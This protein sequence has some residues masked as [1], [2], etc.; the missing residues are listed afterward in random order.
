LAR[1]P[2]PPEDFS[3]K[4]LNI[5]R[6][7]SLFSNPALQRRL[8]VSN[9]HDGPVELTPRIAATVDSIF[10]PV[11][12]SY[13][14]VEGKLEG[15]ITHGTRRFYVYESLTG[16]QVRCLFADSIPLH[17]VLEAFEHRVSVSGVIR[18]KAKTGERLSIV[19]TE[20]RVF[21]DDKD[22]LSHQE[23]LQLWRAH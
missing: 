6:K 9:G 11:T 20:F 3:D 19:P 17:Q 12:E 14:S 1:F 21:R 4:S 7:L 15:I 13:G 16:R 10:G 2:D 8:I 18:S 5:A 22:L 23:I